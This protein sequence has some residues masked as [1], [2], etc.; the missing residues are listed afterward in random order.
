MLGYIQALIDVSER[1]LSMI[2]SKPNPNQL[3]IIQH[4]NYINRLK[5]LKGFYNQ[6]VTLESLKLYHVQKNVRRK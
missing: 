3:Q 1:E 4:E 2:K 5:D 6:Q